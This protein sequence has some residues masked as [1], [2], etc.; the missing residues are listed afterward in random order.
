MRGYQKNRREVYFESR[1]KRCLT[2][3]EK[4]NFRQDFVVLYERFENVLVCIIYFGS[5]GLF[6]PISNFPLFCQNKNSLE[7]LNI[8]FDSSPK[9]FFWANKKKFEFLA[10]S[11]DSRKLQTTALKKPECPEMRRT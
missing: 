3:C 7:L 2:H 5:E 10:L 4:I 1:F 6:R 9:G 11:P 8:I